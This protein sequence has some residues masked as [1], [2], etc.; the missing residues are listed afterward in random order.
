MGESIPGG[1][2]GGLASLAN[3]SNLGG[4]A[5]SVADN[6]GDLVLGVGRR[7][8][9]QRDGRGLVDGGIGRQLKLGQRLG[10]LG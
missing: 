4:N 8:V 10:Y 3:G 5:T 9:G 1:E 6:K 7:P 2:A